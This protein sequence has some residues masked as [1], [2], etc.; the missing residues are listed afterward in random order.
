MLRGA[1]SQLRSGSIA[2]AT[3]LLAEHRRQ[4]PRGQLVDLRA[5]LEIDALCRQGQHA[6]AQSM[7]RSFAQRYPNSPYRARVQACGME[8]TGR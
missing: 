3:A 1:Q 8:V 2:E 4:F 6:R 5:A 7:L